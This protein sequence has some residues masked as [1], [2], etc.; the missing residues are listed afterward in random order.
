MTRAISSCELSCLQVSVH[1]HQFFVQPIQEVPVASA[2]TA[3]QR[4]RL[5]LASNAQWPEIQ[6]LV[7]RSQII[8]ADPVTDRQPDTTQL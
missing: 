4:N 3:V 7:S 5:V 6:P 1:S 8:S 2:T